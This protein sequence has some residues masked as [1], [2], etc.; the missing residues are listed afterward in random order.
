VTADRLREVRA[1]LGLSWPALAAA[2]GRADDRALRRWASGR[3]AIPAADAAWLEAC[4]AA[5]A[6][7]PRPGRGGQEDSQ[8]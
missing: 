8:S 6:V 5:G 7:L 4:A 1:L 3:Q 2:M